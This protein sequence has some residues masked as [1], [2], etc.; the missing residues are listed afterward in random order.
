MLLALAIYTASFIAEI[1]RAGI[2]AVSHGQTEAS[3]ALGL[4]SGPTLRLVIH[5]TDD[6]FWDGP[7]VGNGVDIQYGYADTVAALQQ[8]Q[9]P[10]CREN[11]FEAYALHQIRAHLAV[12]LAEEDSRRPLRLPQSIRSVL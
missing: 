5:T 7:T 11:D 9:P 12:V 3:Y 2:Q 10:R 4:R 8:A 6:T 1:V